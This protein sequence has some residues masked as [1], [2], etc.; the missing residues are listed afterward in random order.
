MKNPS[1][2]QIKNQPGEWYES[3]EFEYTMIDPVT[4]GKW[5]YMGVTRKTPEELN[6]ILN[7]HIISGAMQ[8]PKR[9]Q[10]SLMKG[11]F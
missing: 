7:T 10:V 4:G 3:D 11:L 5:I 9:S 1:Q 2:K 8:R 6:Q